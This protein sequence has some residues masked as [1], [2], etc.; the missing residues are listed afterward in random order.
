MAENGCNE[1]TMIKM[2]IMPYSLYIHY[3]YSL[4]YIG[5]HCI[6]VLFVVILLY[7]YCTHVL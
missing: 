7:I 3:L 4:Q 2:K 6:D 5:V 1:Y